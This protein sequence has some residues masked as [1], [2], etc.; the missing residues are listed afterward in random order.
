V[1]A[2]NRRTTGDK[3]YLRC[4]QNAA[5]AAGSRRRG[6][7]S[8]TGGATPAPFTNDGKSLPTFAVTPSSTRISATTPFAGA[9]ISVDFVGFDVEQS[10]VGLHR[11]AD[12]SAGNDALGNGFAELRMMTSILSL[13][14]SL[15]KS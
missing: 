10:L 7:D 15:I 6:C 2:I 12:F 4:K 11:I 14:R 9:G 1:P 3:R 8:R 5:R 13:N